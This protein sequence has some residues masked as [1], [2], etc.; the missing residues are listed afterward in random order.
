MENILQEIKSVPAVM[1]S[2]LHVNGVTAV[3]SDLPK[4][5]QNKVYEIGAAVDRIIKVNESTK[6]HAANIE[7]R[8]DEAVILIR[9]I[10]QDASLITFC[11]TEVNRKKLNMT[12]GMLANELKDAAERLRKG[13]SSGTPAPETA[14]APPAPKAAAPKDQEIDINKILHAGPLAS[15][16]RD[17][18]NAFAMAIGPIGEMVMKDTVEAWAKK[19]ECNEARLNELAEMLCREIDDQSLEAEFREAVR[20][21]L[22]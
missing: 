15:V 9:P 13:G 18:Q 5:F 6:M 2:Y 3:T 20:E 17:F 14:P 19:G 22:S 8:Y 11:E 7:F 10:D 4:I 16:F 1:G 21:H 12:T